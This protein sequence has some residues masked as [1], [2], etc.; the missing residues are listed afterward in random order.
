MLNS[1]GLSVI[2]RGGG[3]L[4]SGTAL[5][6]HRS[7]F[8]V[9]ITEV[10]QPL[11]VR[12]KV[13][14]GEAVYSGSVNVEGV[15]AQLVGDLND[16]VSV[17]RN[18]NIPVIVDP[19]AAIR[20]NYNPD[21]IVDGRML[22]N[23]VELNRTEGN[24][25]IN[26]H[27]IASG[28]TP[29]LIGLGPG[30]SAGW[31][32]HAAV[33]TRRGHFLGRVIWVGETEADT[34]IPDSVGDYSESRVLRAPA[35]GILTNMA[36]IGDLLAA[37]Q[38]IAAVACCKVTAPFDGVLRGILHPGLSVTRGMKIGDLDPRG[39]PRYCSMV[40]DKALAVAGGVLEAILMYFKAK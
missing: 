4:A 9:L 37:G 30:F 38:P 11:M 24:Q 10:S 14:F 34:G 12:R 6:L 18:G 5:R 29:M 33:E 23:A 17:L 39:D 32:C 35:D 7:G 16:G 8:H 15:T 1:T 25:P 21:V 20:S 28:V 36:E 13:S 27:H 22:K 40:S 2:I 26:D 3:D 19:E 31:N